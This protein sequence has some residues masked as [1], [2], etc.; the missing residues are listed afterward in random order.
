MTTFFCT[1]LGGPNGSGKST[2]Y[3]L[4]KPPGAFVNADVVA[5]EMRSTTNP[6]YLD[7]VAGKIVVNR[8]EKLIA[9]KK[10]FVFETTLSSHHSL[11]VMKKAAENNYEVG[12]VFV[13]LSSADLNVDRV[14][15]RVAR[16]GHDIPADVIRRRYERSLDNLSQAISLANVTHIF[17]NSGQE[18]VHI[19]HIEKGL[20]LSTALNAESALHQRIS[21]SIGIALNIDANE[22]FKADSPFQ[23]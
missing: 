7:A 20:V 12:L 9:A 1:I 2:A 22:L 18:P 14:A 11:S 16:G 23:P 5:A 19:T 3:E 6:S 15:N 21:R 13:A 10:D 4:I 8:L 17:D